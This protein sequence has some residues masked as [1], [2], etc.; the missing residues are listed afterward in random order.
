MKKANEQEYRDEAEQ[1]A[2]SVAAVAAAEQRQL[3]AMYRGDAANAKLAKRDRD[4]ARARADA[5]EK[6]L[7]LSQRKHKKA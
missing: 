3:L 6:L 4:F 1:W 7:K 2:R 5:L